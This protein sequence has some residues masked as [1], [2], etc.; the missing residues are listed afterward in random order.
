MA[1]DKHLV[2]A[3]FDT[4]EKAEEVMKVVQ[5]A[6]RRREA[7]DVGNIAVV[8]KDADGTI[9]LHE[10]EDHKGLAGEIAG[11]LAGAAAWIAYTVSGAGNAPTAGSLAYEETENAIDRRVRDHGFSD[12]ELYGLGERLE[13]GHSALVVLVRAKD[14]PTIT[15]ELEEFGGT[16]IES[17]VPDS[18]LPQLLGDAG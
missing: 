6:D 16:V 12:E 13:A 2:I 17:A 1:D 9:N 11:T 14:V 15:T 3:T 4:A 8:E 5:Q 18:Q 7:V 10:T